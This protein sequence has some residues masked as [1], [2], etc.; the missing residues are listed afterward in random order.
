MYSV[1][2]WRV[3]R[4][5]TDSQG[6]CAWMRSLRNEKLTSVAHNEATMRRLGKEKD[7]EMG[8]GRYIRGKERVPTTVYFPPEFQGNFFPRGM[9]VVL[10][11]SLCCQKRL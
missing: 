2:A 7:E 4:I 11:Q 5:G 6:S 10:P 9:K 8:Q 3:M 1:L